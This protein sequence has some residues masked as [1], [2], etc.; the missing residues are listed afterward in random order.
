[1]KRSSFALLGA[2]LIGGLAP[3]SPLHAQSTTASIT[4][5]RVEC[6]DGKAAGF[7]C[8]NVDLLSF[9]HFSDIGATTP[10]GEPNHDVSLSDLWGWTDPQ[11]GREFALVGHTNGTSF[12]EVSDPE[13]PVYLGNLPAHDG[14]HTMWRDLKVYGDHVFVVAESPDHGMQVFD[15]RL[16]PHLTASPVQF[17]ETAHY[18][19]IA[20][21]HN[22]AINEDTGY[23]YV[24]GAN[25]GGTTCGGGLHIIDVRTPASPQFVGCFAD[26]ET[27][28]SLAGYTHDTQ[29]VIYH[30]PDAAYQGHE[31]CLA[32]NETA[33]SI[34]DVADKTSPTVLSR[35]THPSFA[36]V[37][38][39]WLTMDHG[40]FLINDELDERR[41]Q[42]Q[43]KT[44]IWDV[45]DLDDPVLTAHYQ[46]VSTSIDHNLYI[47]GSFAFQAN[48]TSGLRILDISVIDQPTEVAFFDTYPRNDA[49]ADPETHI[50]LW[51]GA[52]SN[53]PFFESGIVL[54]SSVGEGLFVLQPTGPVNID[55]ETAEV[56]ASGF[57]L[58]P[59][60]P[61]PFSE[62]TRISLDTNRSQNVRIAVYNLAGQRV[63]V[64]HVG[65]LPS[66]THTF[67]LESRDLA[68]GVYVVRATGSDA[69]TTT[70]Q[71]VLLR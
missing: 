58:S 15:L 6:T 34:I 35:A 41:Q 36:Y 29:C 49:T 51:R 40:Y 9:L 13:N 53:Y 56:P 48:Y 19:N 71:V 31:I 16:L 17:T 63:D 8:Q 43:T 44:F 45:Q 52:W 22:I 27:G 2:L 26:T 4:G 3:Y 59:I 68:N 18:D 61:N 25:G 67:T 28:L 42:G 55:R 20:A 50:V 69:A 70:Q 65:M 64:L 14:V 11:T 54:V 46:G 38:Q 23:A 66:G 24:L 1:M 37:H 21:A 5:A 30:G 57:R 7:D 62:S 32:A 33:L 10:F 12:I 39:G 60:Y 47:R